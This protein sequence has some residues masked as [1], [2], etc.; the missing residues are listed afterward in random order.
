MHVFEE[1]EKGLFFKKLKNPK[2]PVYGIKGYI[3]LNYWT[4]FKNK[5]LEGFKLTKVII[6][7]VKERLVI[8][9]SLTAKIEKLRL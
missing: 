2:Y 7:R 4:I 3:L 9:N 8:D 1:I 6:K 5:R